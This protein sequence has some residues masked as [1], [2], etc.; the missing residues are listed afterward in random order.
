MHLDSNGS[1]F[2]SSLGSSSR[3]SACFAAIAGQ[4]MFLTLAWQFEILV[5][6]Y[7][8]IGLMKGNS[9]ASL[10][11]DDSTVSGD[12]LSGISQETAIARG[13]GSTGR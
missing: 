13:P 1:P 3:D 8:F 2:R 11:S 5:K 10:E 7:I 4:G 12:A 6:M 9:S